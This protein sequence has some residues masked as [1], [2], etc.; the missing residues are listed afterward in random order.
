[1]TLP[2]IGI[3]E[4]R[5]RSAGLFSQ[6][7]IFNLTNEHLYVISDELDIDITGISNK[8]ERVNLLWQGCLE[9]G[10]MQLLYE[11]TQPYLFTNRGTITWFQ[12]END[13]NLPNS[14]TSAT[15]RFFA[16]PEIKRA[17]E[18]E[19]RP[20]LTA[21]NRKP[22]LNRVLSLDENA[23]LLEFVQLG[24]KYSAMQYEIASVYTFNFTR[25]LLNFATGFL[26]V[27]GNLTLS[28]GVVT[29]LND[30]LRPVLAENMF[31]I[32]KLTEADY[33]KLKD[34]LGAVLDGTKA[35][36]NGPDPY[37]TKNVT[38]SP[39]CVDLESEEI[40]QE[41]FKDYERFTNTLI[42]S[43]KIQRLGFPQV[44]VRINLLE[45]HVTFYQQY[46]EEVL[47][48]FFTCLAKVKGL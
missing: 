43:S 1:M 21:E 39:D 8:E 6:R 7:D 27:R 13:L 24:T 47:T 3:E 35:K 28:K 20:N 23:V 46:H 18:K 9:N 5:C 15:D 32:V 2:E 40:F 12:L 42:Y 31:H 26:E 48:E 38:K 37:D 29:A 36:N 33:L 34:T 11:N 44:K 4:R 45:G 16:L 10:T 25:C 17:S 19:I 30:L 41:E 14:K 22:L